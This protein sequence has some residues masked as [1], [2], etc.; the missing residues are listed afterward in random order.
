MFTKLESV[1]HC[2]EP[3]KLGEQEEIQSEKSRSGQCRDY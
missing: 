2:I 3:G 1:N